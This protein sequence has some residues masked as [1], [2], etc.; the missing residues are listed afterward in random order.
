[1][2]LRGEQ[3]RTRALGCLREPTTAIFYTQSWFS[4]SYHCILFQWATK[5]S[6]TFR[7]AETIMYGFMNKTPSFSQLKIIG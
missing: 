6:N 2:K 7:K 4:L 5:S 1:M 3:M